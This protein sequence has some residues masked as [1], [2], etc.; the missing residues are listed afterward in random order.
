MSEAAHLCLRAQ[1]A[2]GTRRW[3]H[4]ASAA[5]N[6]LAQRVVLFRYGDWVFVTFGL[7]A[8][9]G[10]LVSLTAMGALLIGQGVGGKFFLTLAVAG[11]ATVVV[12][13]WLAGQLLDYRLLLE[14]PWRALRRPVF[15]SWGGIIALPLVLAIM[16]A[17]ADVSLLV[18]L[19]AAARTT[20]LGHALGRLGCLTYGCCFGRPTDAALAITYRNPLA[21]AVRV[22][23]L[24]NVPL[25]PAP[26]YEVV[27]QIGLALVVNLA[28]VLG[29]PLGLPT[30]LAFVLYGMGRFAVEFTRDNSGRMIV[31]P[32]AVNH[33]VALSFVIGGALAIPA[34][35]LGWQVPPAISWSAA[36]AGVPELAPAITPGVVLIFFGFSL[37]RGRIGEW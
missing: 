24:H 4:I 31:A 5:L 16:A 32:L 29:A 28:A 37:H 14:H 3:L 27:L 33:L 22:A 7:F 2:T 6:W 11:S 12:G 17:L 26:F 13:S 8:G 21:K 9:L 23:G 25:H 19:D 36:L 34:L 35:L 15:V 18:L 30:A 20:P 10:A 1:Q